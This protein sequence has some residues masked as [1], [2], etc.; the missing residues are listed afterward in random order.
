MRTIIAGSRTFDDFDL[1]CS[2]ISGLPWSISEVVS[3][4]AYG[5]DA[6][7][8]K[9]AREH[10]VFLK[11]FPAQWEKYGKRAGYLRNV[12]MGE[13]GEALLA[14]WDG[15]SRGTKHMINIARKKGLQVMVI[16]F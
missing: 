10:H 3:G 8:E 9:W 14:F 1:L 16:Y 6:L 11:R 15:V 2:T 5:A 4:G 12:E 13:Y 7:G